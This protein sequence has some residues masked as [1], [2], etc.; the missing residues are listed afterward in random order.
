MKIMLRKTKE[1][2]VS[3]YVAKKDLETDVVASEHDTLWGGWISLANGWRLELPATPP[4]DT[5][6]MTVEARRLEG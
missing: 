4:K 2:V 3:V 5:W 1:G 6:P